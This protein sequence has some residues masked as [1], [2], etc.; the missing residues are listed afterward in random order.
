MRCLITGGAGFLGRHLAMA[1][2]KNGHKVRCLDIYKPLW[3]NKD[4]VEFYKGDFSAAHLVA[5]AMAGCDV[6][7]HLAWT[8]LPQ[9]SN[10]DPDFDI[11][12]N[13]QG[14]VRMLDEAVKLK[15]K[16]VIFMS[17]GGTVYGVPSVIPTPETHQTNPTCSYGITK[18]TIEK[19]LRLYSSLHGLNTCSLRLSNPYGEY[20]GV[21]SIQGVVSVFCYKAIM[22]QTIQIW[23]DGSVKRDFV[24]VSDVADAM[25]KVLD[26]PSTGYEVNIGSGKAVSINGIIEYIENVLGKKV[27][28]QY[29][30]NRP[31]D[32]PVST[33]DISLAREKLNWEPKVDILDGIGRTARWIEKSYLKG[34]AGS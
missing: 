12:S 16:K 26:S 5:D 30:A 17:S 21:N 27:H 22:G 31:F 34:E 33:L 19:Y 3:G 14:T 28:R 8:T 10:E 25:I 4:N 2:L 29:S 11:V 15:V 20:Q 24:Y 1:L 13:V 23:G 7:F 32:V 6:I 18:L 9:T